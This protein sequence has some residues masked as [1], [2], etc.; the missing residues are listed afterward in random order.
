MP[1]LDGLRILD[2][3]QY[4]AGTSCTQALAWMGADVVKIEST[5]FGDPGRGIAT[6]S[7]YSP[8]FCNWN[9]NK[10][11]V[12]LNLQQE[13]GRDLLKK[14]LP[15]FDVFIENYGP[16]VAERLGVAYEDLKAVHPAVIHAQIRGFGDS[17]PYSQYKSYDMVAQAASGAFSITGEPD[18]PPLLPGP[19]FGDS[20][21]GVQMG[22][23]ILAAY[24]QR[25]RTGEGQHIEISMQEAMTYFMRT[26]IS[27]AGEWGK[28]V[29]PRAGNS[30][31][32]GPTGLY[33]CKPFGSN[34]WLYLITVTNPHWDALCMTIDRVDMV[35]DERFSTGIARMQN[36]PALYEEIA[37]W[38]REHTK[39]EA[40]KILGEAGVPCS[41]TLDTKD[42]YEDPHLQARDFIQTVEHPELGEVPLLGWAPRLSNSE[43]PFERAPLLGEHTED[44]L[45]GE[46]GLSSE[47]LAALEDRGV[48]RRA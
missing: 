29:A 7:D 43:V 9:A 24:V 14:L 18:G 19:T 27:F 44:V 8:Y 42:L 20:G 10:K 4:E 5:T 48:I 15:A 13:A 46:L 21:T 23:A 1:A 39:H 47:D 41:A 34:D 40:M 30:M 38:T 3:T 33:P 32:S 28:G 12:S 25:L 11:S 35:A 22:M 37:T 16:G 36:G 31:G 26:R 2:M 45:Q 17:G 6:G